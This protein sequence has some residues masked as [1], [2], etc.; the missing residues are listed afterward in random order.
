MGREGLRN[1]HGLIVY[2]YIKKNLL[3]HN[4][5]VILII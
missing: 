5:I 2:T 4:V 1:Y 3:W